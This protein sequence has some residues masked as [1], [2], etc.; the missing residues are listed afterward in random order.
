MKNTSKRVVS[1]GVLAL[2]VLAACKPAEDEVPLGPEELEQQRQAVSER[3]GDMLVA[4]SNHSATLLS[5]GKLLVAGG[6]STELGVQ[7]GRTLR[8][9]SR[10][11]GVDGLHVHSACAPLRRAPQ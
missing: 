7:R 5:N 2:F 6:D 11:V 4:R 8:S 9:D 10:D 3:T 1:W